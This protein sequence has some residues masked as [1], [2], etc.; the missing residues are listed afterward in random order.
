MFWKSIVKPNSVITID[1][2]SSGK[3]GPIVFW[4]IF[5][6]PL[7]G[8]LCQ[9]IVCIFIMYSLLDFLYVVS[10]VVQSSPTPFCSFCSCSWLSVTFV[11]F[12][13][14][15]IRREEA[16]K[17]EVNEISWNIEND[18]FFLTNGQG[19]VHV[20]SYPDMELMTTLQVPQPH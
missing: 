4:I 15:K 17:F 7:S 10:S 20:H 8:I 1:V 9:A 2:V 18:L 13:T 19:C 11:D 5:H 3:V 14:Q 16:F 12:K 6:V